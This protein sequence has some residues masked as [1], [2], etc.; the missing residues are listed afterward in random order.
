L[1]LG[2]IHEINPN[3]EPPFILL[4]GDRQGADTVLPELRPH[5][6]VDDRPVFRSL[7]PDGGV[8]RIASQQPGTLLPSPCLFLGLFLLLPG[9]EALDHNL[10]LQIVVEGAQSMQGWPVS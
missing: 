5:E 10:A 1:E 6:G 2:I 7:K 9:P 4:P 3:D 8:P